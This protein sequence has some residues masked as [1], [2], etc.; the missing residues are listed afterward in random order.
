MKTKKLFSVA[1][2]AVCTAVM[3]V[4]C[5]KEGEPVDSFSVLS[6]AVVGESEITGSKYL[7]TYSYGA[8]VPDDVSTLEEYEVGDCASAR[9][10]IDTR[11]QIENAPYWIG[12]GVRLE[13]VEQ[14][15]VLYSEQPED[16]TEYSFPI[17]GAELHACYT[18]AFNYNG[19][20]F[21]NTKNRIAKTQKVIYSLQ[22]DWS[23]TDENGAYVLCLKGKTIGVEGALETTESLNAFDLN[24]MFD[25]QNIWKEYVYEDNGK[26]Y[27]C[28]SLTLVLKYFTENNKGEPVYNYINKSASFTVYLY[29]EN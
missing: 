5:L 12:S 27:K 21:V 24:A 18:S 16:T 1:V 4:G 10:T 20:L 26:E 15:A 7:S 11:K 9:F 2:Y 22:C 13:R 14:T 29:K 25:N 28:R 17:G 6:P 3:S 19:R 23:E 8:V